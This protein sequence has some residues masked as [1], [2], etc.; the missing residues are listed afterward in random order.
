MRC[1]RPR[2]PRDG[3]AA[4]KVAAV[5]PTLTDGDRA[6]LL[7][8]VRALAGAPLQKLWLPS[9]QVCV[10]QLR[11]PGRTVLAVADARLRMAALADE[12]PTA[13]ESAPRSQ[14][15]L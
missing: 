2:V 9:A 11:V 3:S 14:A 4:R 6:R 5:S 13:P 15:T 1:G 7:A 10:L 12:R 8:E